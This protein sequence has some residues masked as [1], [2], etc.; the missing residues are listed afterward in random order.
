LRQFE[1]LGDTM[2]EI[3]AREIRTADVFVVMRP[4]GSS[5]NPKN[6]VESVLFGTE[7]RS[8]IKRFPPVG[9]CKC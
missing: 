7:L 1:A 2:G 3:A 6:L 5:R 4:N 8:A 9:G